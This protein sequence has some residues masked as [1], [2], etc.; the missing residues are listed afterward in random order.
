M[1]KEARIYMFM[2]KCH[3]SSMLAKRDYYTTAGALTDSDCL[4]RNENLKQIDD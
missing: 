4:A 3:K 2:G 1:A